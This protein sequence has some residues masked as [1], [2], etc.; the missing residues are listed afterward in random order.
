MTNKILS[1][2]LLYDHYRN[3][4][5]LEL[6]PNQNSQLGFESL[7]YGYSG[8]DSNFYIPKFPDVKFDFIDYGNEG[9]LDTVK[10]MLS[11][12]WKWLKEFISRI[13]NWLKNVIIRA[14][15]YIK[16]II[17]KILGIRNK[18]S[19]NIPPQSLEQ[20]VEQIK[21]Y[22]NN[23]KVKVLSNTD[24][25]N[26][27]EL[28]NFITRNIERLLTDHLEY[29]LN[30][31]VGDDELRYQD[32]TKQSGKK[33]F[34]EVINKYNLDTSK[35]SNNFKKFLL[36]E[37]D[38][39]VEEITAIQAL[40]LL[41][42]PN[43][44]NLSIL[45]AKTLEEVNRGYDELINFLKNQVEIIEDK[46]RPVLDNIEFITIVGSKS[47]DAKAFAII[48]KM[49]GDKFGGGDP[50][51]YD[52]IMSSKTKKHKLQKIIFS[53]L[54]TFMEATIQFPTKIISRQLYS[55]LPFFNDIINK[56]VGEF[57]RVAGLTPLN[58]ITLMFKE[59]KNVENFMKILNK[60][61]YSQINGI[62]VYSTDGLIEAVIDMSNNFHGNSY[63][64]ENFKKAL[65][66]ISKDKQRML[67]ASCISIKDSIKNN[68]IIVIGSGL[69]K[70]LSKDEID[71]VIGHE[72]GHYK[73]THGR[74]TLISVL[75]EIVKTGKF[76]YNMNTRKIDKE[77]EADLY[78]AQYSTFDAA[79]NAL[80]KIRP[81]ILGIKL[82]SG[83][84]KIFETDIKYRIDFLK[85]AKKK[86]GNIDVQE[87]I[88]THKL[89]FR[90]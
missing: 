78:G 80:S 58:T 20:A 75:N 22:L 79:I 18:Q 14:I 84:F 9:F 25:N 30:V 1:N 23:T 64:I 16:S 13:Y 69:I 76:I 73:H 29:L 66:E 24:F 53:S 90:Y 10:D 48:T 5:L 61:Q 49:F 39:Y 47:A 3:I 2:K 36:G 38:D 33:V 83:L 50:N 88:R 7:N 12:F 63:E 62:P 51:Y 40:Q 11:R 28:T 46:Y 19:K 85:E 67:N 60:Y 65:Y 70:K 68:V 37:K 8:I 89:N 56:V 55:S 82:D 4:K 72:Y 54:I 17:Y 77:L 43:K 15:N 44:L 42:E 27:L 31:N 59:T 87:Y 74:R 34:Q 21:T 57:K 86:D 32:S 6:Y 81:S 35:L 52:S 71:Y 45:S 26:I 41:A